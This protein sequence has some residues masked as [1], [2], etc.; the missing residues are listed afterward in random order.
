MKNANVSTAIGTKHYSD[1]MKEKVCREYLKGG[2]SLSYLSNKYKIAGHH[3]F[4]GWLGNFGDDSMKK[5]P[6]EKMIMAKPKKEDLPMTME[7]MK[8]RI[9]ELERQLEDAEFKVELNER[10]IEIAE[11][12]LNIQIRKKSDTK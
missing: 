10:I 9:R 8:I 5:E 1:R 11:E 12:E 2:V 3:T 7:Q 4:K 6:Q